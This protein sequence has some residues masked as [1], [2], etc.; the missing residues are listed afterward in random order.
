MENTHLQPEVSAVR[1]SHLGLN[2]C[3]NVSL[4][5]SFQHMSAVQEQH[6]C[7][8]MQLV[9]LM[10]SCHII[11]PYQKLWQIYG[12]AL[13][14]GK[15]SFAFV[16][17]CVYLHCGRICTAGAVKM[18]VLRQKGWLAYHSIPLILQHRGNAEL[19][20]LLSHHFKNITSWS[21]VNS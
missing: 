20:S 8:C 11:S 3:V 17:F 10:P 16:F 12:T 4:G 6:I 7:V 15:Q 21:L 18:F 2:S 9:K 13:S 1:A 5:L 14:A 19:C